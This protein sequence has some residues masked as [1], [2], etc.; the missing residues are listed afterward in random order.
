MFNKKQF[1]V[2]V[3]GDANY[4][5]HTYCNVERLSPDQPVAVVDVT[6][7]ERSGGMAKNVERNLKALGLSVDCLVNSNWKKITKNRILDIKTL[8]HFVRVDDS[9]PINR[10][11]LTNIDW[12]R[13]NFILIADYKKGSLIEED[14]KFI[15]N[16]HPLTILDTKRILGKYAET[17]KFIKI[18]RKEYAASEKFLTKKLKDRIITTLGSDGTRFRDKI[19]PVE[20]AEVRNVS[21]AGDAHMSSYVYAYLKSSGDIDKSIRFANKVCTLI[22]QKRGIGVIDK[23]ELKELNKEFGF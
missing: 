21:G 5:L 2:L 13:Y 16:S 12:K 23:K 14:I 22:V 8:H 9:E 17:I 15:G 1:K 3:I 19:Y 10:L 20:E 11:D 4:D 7:I 18:N 6:K